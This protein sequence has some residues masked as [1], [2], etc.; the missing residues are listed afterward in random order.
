MIYRFYILH[1]FEELLKLETPVL[2]ANNLPLTIL[3]VV[4]VRT[5]EDYDDGRTE[6][7]RQLLYIAE[8]AKVIFL[9]EEVCKGLVQQV[10]C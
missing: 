8:E 3:G 7:T 1:F 5:I 6:K 2:D 4:F 9:N 10:F